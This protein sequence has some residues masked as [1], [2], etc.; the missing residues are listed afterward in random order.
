MY[1]IQNFQY[2]LFNTTVLLLVLFLLPLT[3]PGQEN[4]PILDSYPDAYAAYS[5]RKLDSEY[6]GYAVRVRS[7]ADDT[8]KSFGFDSEGNLNIS[9]IES[10]LGA[11]DGYVTT[12]FS[13]KSGQTDL[14]QTDK[15]RQPLIAQDGT[16]ILD[17]KGLPRI[18]FEGDRNTYL[19]TY[20]GSLSSI[21]INNTALMIVGE[22]R[23][24][25]ETQGVLALQ[26][27]GE[28]G[29]YKFIL[30]IQN[31]ALTFRSNIT[32]QVWTGIRK[33]RAVW[34]INFDNYGNVINYYNNAETKTN[35][36]SGSLSSNQ[37]TV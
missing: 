19:T 12:W 11:A 17:E 31:N 25:P 32:S 22:S 2:L 34:G 33:D 4:G 26:R 9:E 27:P 10:W 6:T 3:A 5:L 14:V 1:K 8:E 16:V 21:P 23:T 24:S 7:S 18:L 29:Q 15:T 20:P 28:W 37:L 36:Y 30:N 13:Q 35:T